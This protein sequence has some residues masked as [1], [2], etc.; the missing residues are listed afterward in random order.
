METSVIFLPFSRGMD[1]RKSLEMSS[2]F[3]RD[4]S[5]VYSR[6]V[7]PKGHPLY[8]FAQIPA[9]CTVADECV[10]SVGAEVNA[11]VWRSESGVAINTS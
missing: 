5:P 11:T 1:N 8:S 2:M 9:C 3:P 6:S 10:V 4:N 7:M